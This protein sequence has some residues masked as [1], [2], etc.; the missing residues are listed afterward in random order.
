VSHRSPAATAFPPPRIVPV[1]PVGG[2]FPYLSPYT[3]S[4]EGIGR[5]ASNWDNRDFSAAPEPSLGTP[6]LGGWGW[7]WTT[8]S[9]LPPLVRS[10][11]SIPAVNIVCGRP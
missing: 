7:R 4:W 1:A 8:A 9:L 11:P 5:T 3:R 2:L 6:M 10:S